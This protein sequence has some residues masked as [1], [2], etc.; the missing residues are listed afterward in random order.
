M[1]TQVERL[2]P[3]VPYALAALP[4][5]VPAVL[6]L[7]HL[8]VRRGSPFRRALAISTLDVLLLA[9]LAVALIMTLGPASIPGDRRLDLIPFRELQPR[10]F[11]HWSAAAEMTGNVVLFI[12]LAF[13]GMIRYPSLRSLLRVVSL[14]F[15]LSLFLEASQF[16]IRVG[17]EASVTDVV[18]N[19]LGS[20]MGYW[21][22]LA[23][24]GW[25][26]RHRRP[27]PNTG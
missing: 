1:G 3:L 25:R 7:T 26:G 23:A 14:A 16:I 24:I 11:D 10:G 19:T 15:G 4:I 20:V 9:Y 8:R 27:V 22:F 17:R 6:W 13:L 12:P 18:L 5:G 2:Q 21:L